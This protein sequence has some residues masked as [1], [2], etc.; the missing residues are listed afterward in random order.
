MVRQSCRLLIMISMMITSKKANDGRA[1][2]PSAWGAV[3]VVWCVVAAVVKGK[4]SKE[5]GAAL[6]QASTAL[7]AV[8]IH[9][10]L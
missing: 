8:F 4:R 10:Q 7:A 9:D 3:V 2:A 5:Q 1:A 6:K